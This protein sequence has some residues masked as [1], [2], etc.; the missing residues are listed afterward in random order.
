DC[1]R[2]R[3]SKR[4]RNVTMR[5][6]PKSRSRGCCANRESLLFPK[7]ARKSMSATTHDQSRSNVPT[8]ISPIWIGNFHR[9]NPKDRCRC[10]KLSYTATT[11]QLPLICYP[12]VRVGKVLTCYQNPVSISAYEDKNDWINSGVLLFG[13]SSMLGR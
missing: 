7:R 4:S 9:P 10:C 11:D 5:P 8:K 6:L 12:L 1:S 2:A 3:R 13:R